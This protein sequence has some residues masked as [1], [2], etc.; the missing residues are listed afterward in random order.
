MTPEELKET[1]ASYFDSYPSEN[2][3][4]MTSDGQVFLRKNAN[5]AHNHQLRIDDKKKVQTYHRD[6]GKSEEDVDDNPKITPD[7][8]W[9]KEEIVGWLTAAGVDADTK[10]KKDDL[11]A[12]VAG[13]LTSE[14]DNVDPDESWDNEELVDW[15]QVAGV[16]A[17]VDEEKEALLEKVKAV[18]DAEGGR[19]PGPDEGEE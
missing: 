5:D 11:M 8:S 19:A 3:L 17:H 4:L 7:Q 18:I 15:L 10:E 6:G 1:L 2:E 12:K 14:E 16:E 9:T 13:H